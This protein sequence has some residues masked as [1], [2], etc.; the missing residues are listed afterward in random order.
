MNVCVSINLYSSIKGSKNIAVDDETVCND[1]VCHT[2]KITISKWTKHSKPT[3]S[4]P[5]TAPYML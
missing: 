3:I 5:L 4:K 1:R 2:R